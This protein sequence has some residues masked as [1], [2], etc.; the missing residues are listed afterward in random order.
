MDYNRFKILLVVRIIAMVLAISLSLYC[1][2]ILRNYLRSFFA[3][4]LV[5]GL[6]TDFYL[7]LLHAFT[8]VRSFLSALINNDFSM[9]RS[10]P[11]HRKSVS[12]I[13]ELFQKLSTKYHKISTEKEVQHLFLQNLVEQV[14]VGIIC[15]END[16]SVFLV[17][18]TL[19]ELV[20]TAPVHSLD[21]L[22]ER[23]P[24]LYTEFKHI[25]SGENRLVKYHAQGK[26]F[27]LSLLCS[28]FKLLETEY[29]LIT[30]QNIGKELDE[31]EVESWQKLI[32]VLT[33]EIMNSVTP[34]T[35]LTGSLYERVRSERDSNQEI[36]SV[37]LDFLT[38]G[39]EAIGVRSQGLLGFTQAFHHLLRIPKP[40]IEKTDTQRLFERIH[41]L[42]NPVF[43]EH[44]I[45]FS[46][47]VEKEA[48]KVFIDSNLMEQAIINLVKNALE[49]F[50]QNA[51]PKITLQAMRLLNGMVQIV[52]SDNG[53]GIPPENF[54]KVLVPFYTT[55]E[56]GTGIG[57][58]IS[59]QIVQLHKGTLALQSIPGFDTRFIIEIP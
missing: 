25:R 31:K 21:K 36:T 43:K 59:R 11:E 39:L 23:D 16:G 42:F 46:T 49:S 19:K 45:T 28:E 30:I 47:S 33:H 40:V 9:Y 3:V 32:R 55:K 51:E 38:E 54:E 57:L 18:R 14:N 5:A 4:L 56:K 1:I 10:Y 50:A 37:T 15:L 48:S 58:S 13:Y 27:Q 8:D 17:N 26:L 41:V 7:F 44:G 2:F 24:E 53:K 22:A 6:I 20:Q 29:K 12:G 52:V 35:S 34:I